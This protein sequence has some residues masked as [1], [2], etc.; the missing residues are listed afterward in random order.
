MRKLMLIF[1]LVATL[2]I[3]GATVS[4]MT[5]KAKATPQIGPNTLKQGVA[6]T[7]EIQIN[8]TEGARLANS[9]PLVLYSP[10]GSITN[11]THLSVGG[12]G[13]DGSIELVGSFSGVDYAQEL[14]DLYEFSW[15]GNLPDTL[16]HVGLANANGTS[17]WPDDRGNETCMKFHLIVNQMGILCIDSV[18]H[19]IHKFDWLFEDPSPSF[20]GPYC[21]RIGQGY[22]GDRDADGIPDADDNCLTV[23]NPDQIDTD[24]DGVGDACTFE[25]PTPAGS[26]VEV[27]LGSVMNMD[28][29][30]V[31]GSGDTKL[32]IQRVGRSLPSNID[33][34]AFGTQEQYEVTTTATFDNEIEVCINYDD[35]GMDGALESRIRMYHFDGEFWWD[36]TSS[37]DTNTNTLCGI[38]TSLSPFLPGLPNCCMLYGLPGDASSD[39]NV[40]LVDILWIISYVYDGDYGTPPNP[41]GCNALLDAKGDGQ[42]TVL[43]QVNLIDIL[44]LIDHIYEINDPTNPP[45]C[46]PPDCQMP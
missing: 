20:N 24:G 31:N 38:T 5:I 26:D 35:M 8:N 9:L 22:D 12:S 28:F 23:Y 34:A 37:L 33:Y 43:P 15:D 27:E 11:V 6:F 36:I 40:N 25:E 30:S 18:A 4:A 7:I 1:I 10:N 42:S 3:S 2:V 46:C 13:S 44:H 29:H 17:T 41:E 16:A 21:W 39:G 14:N 45:A 32:E 19:P